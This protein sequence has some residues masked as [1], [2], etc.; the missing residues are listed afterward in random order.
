MNAAGAL[1]EVTME[2]VM[3]DFVMSDED[4]NEIAD[5]MYLVNTRY[6]LPVLFRWCHEMN[7]DWLQC[8]TVLLNVLT[9]PLSIRDAASR[10]H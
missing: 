1:F 2:P 6:G 3:E 7:G 9:A 5:F 8:G 10:V 4:V